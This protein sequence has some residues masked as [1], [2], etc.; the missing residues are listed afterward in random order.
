[1]KLEVEMGRLGAFTFVTLNGYFAG[2]N[3]DISWHRHGAEE[4]AY[5]AEALKSGNT[6]L[7]GR[8]TYEMMASYWPTAVATENDPTVAEG[9]N[10]ADKIVF[11]RTLKNAAWS[12]TR[13]VKGDI[14]E[15]IRK[16]KQVPGRNMTLLGSGS[17]LTQ[18]AELGLIDEYQVMVDPV[19]L[20]A[21][22]PVFKG[23]KQTL[24]LKLTATKAFKSGVVLLSYQPASGSLRPYDRGTS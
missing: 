14:G 20:G 12:N 18:L 23:I 2:P 5:A 9:M 24:N 19:A 17:V 8:V 4:N 11:S 3:G 16:L 13:L 7:F 1:V 6:L 10:R 21:G 15:E 22:T